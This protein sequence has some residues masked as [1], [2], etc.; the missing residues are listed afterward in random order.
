M[1]NESLDLNLY[2]IARVGLR[3][4]FV[5]FFSSCFLGV[6]KPDTAIYRLAL[7][8]TQRAPEESVF[9]DDRL[10]N[11]ECA[12]QT[13]LRT[14]RYQNPVQLQDDLRHLGVEV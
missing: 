2:R 11:L 13:G 10:L 8:I 5:A 14:M 7:Q 1:N 12:R 6:R 9:I 3:R 4:Y